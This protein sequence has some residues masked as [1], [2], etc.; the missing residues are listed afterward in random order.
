[1]HCT[2]G[3]CMYRTG[4]PPRP[5]G[6][7]FTTRPSLW[8]W[9]SW[10]W[11]ERGFPAFVWKSKSKQLFKGGAILYESSKCWSEWPMNGSCYTAGVLCCVLIS[12]CRCQSRIWSQTIGQDTPPQSSL[13]DFLPLVRKKWKTSRLVDVPSLICW[14]IRQ[15]RHWTLGTFVATSRQELQ[16][17]EPVDLAGHL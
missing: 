2:L 11:M 8:E 1:M 16:T 14:S 13:I 6:C 15:P 3:E 17:L 9:L 4:S 7:M 12:A 5:I 10:E